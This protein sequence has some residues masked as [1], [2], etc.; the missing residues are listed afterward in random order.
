MLSEQQIKE[1]KESGHYSNLGRKGG[2]APHRKYNWTPG[3]EAPSRAGRR[4]G[5]K[6]KWRRLVESG[7]I[8]EHNQPFEQ[9]F[10]EHYEQE[11]RN[12]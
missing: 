2:S 9:W 5:A 4:G 1:W 8:S 3:A 7:Y 12:V 11:E 6:C 10:K